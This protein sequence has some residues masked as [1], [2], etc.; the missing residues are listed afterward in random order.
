M[1][2]AVRAAILNGSI[3][4]GRFLREVDIASQMGVSRSPVREA[5]RQLQQEGLVDFYPNQGAVVA[6]VPDHEVELIYGLRA[7]IEGEA[8]ATACRVATAA[9]LDRLTDLWYEM[10]R[11]MRRRELPAVMDADLA[12]HQAVVEIA[13]SPFVRRIAASL[14]GVVR[15][16]VMRVNNE[17]DS[18]FRGRVERDVD[19]HL[20]LLDALR[21]RDAERARALAIAHVDLPLAWSRDGVAALDRATADLA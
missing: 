19:S 15:A 14:D 16:T 17:D 6:G 18:E 2:S 7:T 13:G 11:A 4:A 21:S 1:L 10:H 9:D 12:F 8:F 20:P 3:P 5:I